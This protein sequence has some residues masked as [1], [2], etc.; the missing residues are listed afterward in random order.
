MV[1]SQNQEKLVAGCGG[2]RPSER[3]INGGGMFGEDD[4]DDDYDGDG[5]DDD[6]DGGPSEWAING[7]GERCLGRKEKH[8]KAAKK[9]D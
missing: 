4:D 6:G 7:G 3:P 5:G 2:R 8:C 9:P 1:S